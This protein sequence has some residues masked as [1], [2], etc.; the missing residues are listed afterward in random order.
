M[1]SLEI[2][3]RKRKKDKGINK[4]RNKRKELNTV[5]CGFGGGFGPT[6]WT[7]LIGLCV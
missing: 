2:S 4:E 5:N 6:L 7:V 3:E 1:F